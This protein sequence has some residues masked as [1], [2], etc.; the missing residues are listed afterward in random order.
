MQIK[1]IIEGVIAKECREHISVK[2]LTRNFYREY[3]VAGKY[4][5]FVWHIS[6]YDSIGNI[7]KYSTRG[8]EEFL[9]YSIEKLM[10]DTLLFDYTAGRN[11]RDWKFIGNNKITNKIDTLE[12]EI[13]ENGFGDQILINRKGNKVIIFELA[14]GVGTENRI[15]RQNDQ[16]NSLKE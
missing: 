14:V 1:S 9:E 11:I 5:V 10:A 2:Y 3:Y 8:A 6:E 15:Q 4:S 7:V 13:D 16:S 12:V